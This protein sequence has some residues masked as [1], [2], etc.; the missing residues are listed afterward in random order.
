MKGGAG[1]APCPAFPESWTVVAGG[2]CNS[3]GTIR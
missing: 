2:G 1:L 3:T